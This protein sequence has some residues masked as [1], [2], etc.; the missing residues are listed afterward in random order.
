[1]N[2][3]MAVYLYEQVFTCVIAAKYDIVDFADVAELSATGIAD[4]ALDVFLHFT[5]GIGKCTFDGF[6]YTLAFNVFT[7]ALVEV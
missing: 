1:M 4:G 3:Q 6:K 5:Q 7:F 2:V